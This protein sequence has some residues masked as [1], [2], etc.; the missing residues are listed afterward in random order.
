MLHVSELQNPS[1]PCVFSSPVEHLSFIQAAAKNNVQS[2]FEINSYYLSI[3][4][5]VKTYE[6]FFTIIKQNVFLE[7]FSHCDV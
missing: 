2:L 1:V 7:N 4:L 6:G 5:L 3:S